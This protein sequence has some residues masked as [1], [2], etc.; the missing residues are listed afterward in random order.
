MSGAM[1]KRVSTGFGTPFQDFYGTAEIGGIAMQTKPTQT[2]NEPY[3]PTAA[4]GLKVFA[5]QLLVEIVDA[6]G[7]PVLPGEVGRIL[8]TDFF[9]AAMP[10]IRYDVGDLGRWLTTNSFAMNPFQLNREAQI[11]VLG[12]S[13]EAVRLPSGGLVTSRQVADVAFNDPSILNCQLVYRT[14]KTPIA[15]TSGLGEVASGT[16]SS[17]Q[18]LLELTHPMIFKRSSYLR[19]ESSG[20]YCY[21]KN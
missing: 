8:V 19:P 14:G 20:K 13:V 6:E 9:N 7:K 11:E 15:T 4:T 10:L 17:M 5:N 2:K 21:V 18:R 1:A 3:L 16:Q 12:R